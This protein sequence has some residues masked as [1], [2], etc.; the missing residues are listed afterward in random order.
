M[1][2]RANIALE[3]VKKEHVL[4]FRDMYESMIEEME[5]YKKLHKLDELM[6]QEIVVQ[7]NDGNG[8]IL[9]GFPQLFVGWLEGG[10]VCVSGGLDAIIDWGKLKE[11]ILDM[12]ERL[13]NGML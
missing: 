4:T 13:N 9:Q 7:L 12:E 10:G 3:T 8:N 11:D 5:T 2:T 1:D 6:D